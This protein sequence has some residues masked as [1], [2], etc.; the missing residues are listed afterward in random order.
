MQT[1][2]PS[3][4]RWNQHTGGQRRNKQKM[5]QFIMNIVAGTQWQDGPLT[6]SSVVEGGCET[7]VMSLAL[8]YQTS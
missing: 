3:D 8:H 1:C 2:L 5:S 7:S 6:S 4:Q